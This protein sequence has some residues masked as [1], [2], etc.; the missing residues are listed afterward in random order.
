M[1]S[2]ERLK[3]SLTGSAIKLPFIVNRPPDAVWFS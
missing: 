2:N 1:K 3:P